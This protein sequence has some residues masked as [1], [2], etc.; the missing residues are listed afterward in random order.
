MSDPSQPTLKTA[1]SANQY[2]VASD[3]IPFII[4]DSPFDHT[5]DLF[6][7]NTSQQSFRES[8]L[9]NYECSVE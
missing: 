3:S 9:K 2:E 7:N 6:V 8:N 5:I 1:S 4:R